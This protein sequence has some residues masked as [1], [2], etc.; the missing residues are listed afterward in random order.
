MGGKSQSS[1]SSS[2]T[3]NAEDNR[4]SAMDNAIVATDG[5]K[6]T[7]NSLDGGAIESASEFGV[8]AINLVG[9]VALKVIDSAFN[10]GEKSVS[11]VGA[12]NEKT[13]DFVDATNKS[14]NENIMPWL[15]GTTAVVTI[16]TYMI[17]RK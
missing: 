16:A 11:S 3:T 6:L 12:S 15:L 4:V 7:F 5:S 9:D 8:D 14:E 2:S 10:L 17:M 13:L 1:S